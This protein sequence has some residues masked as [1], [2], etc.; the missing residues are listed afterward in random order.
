[1]P[2][3]SKAVIQQEKE[4]YLIQTKLRVSDVMLMLFYHHYMS[5]M[6]TSFF[7]AISFRKMELARICQYEGWH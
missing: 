2:E 3:I 6:V 7:E 5:V 4:N 1:M